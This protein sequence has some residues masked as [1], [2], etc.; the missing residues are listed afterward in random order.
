M[1][2]PLASHMAFAED[3]SIEGG[4]RYSKYSEG[5]TTNT[6]KIG[7]EWAPVRDVRLRGSFQRAVRAPNIGELFSPQ[8]VGLDGSIDPCAGTM[9]PGVSP[10]P[11]QCLAAGVPLAQYGNV[12]KNPSPQYNGLLGGNPNL[13][14]ETADTYTVGFV[15]Q[16]RFAS[17]LTLSVDY[18]DIKIKNVIAFLG[19]NTI[20]LDCIKSLSPQFCN[21]IHRDQ[22][23]SLW[24]TPEGFITDTTV[25]EGELSTKGIDLK[26]SYRVGLPALGSLLL[27]IEGT[28]TQNLI[29]TSVPGFGSY[30]CVGFY[31]ATCG[32]ANP[33]W[34]HVL[35][36]GWNTPWDGLDLNLR[37]RYIGAD[38]SEQ[39]SGN[40]FLA[41]SSFAA[42]H[43]HIPAYNYIDVTG[44]FNIYKNVRL[45]LGMN[46]IAD[47]APPIVAGA[48]C[49]TSSP[50]GANCN[51]NTFPGVYD[52]LGRYIFASFTASF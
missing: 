8:A 35:N 3:L 36:V 23:N 20:I 16:P 4:Y 7:L 38:N 26:G 11:A 9:T 21:A 5:F 47:K 51:G 33:K 10:T 32:A 19:G 50:A 13:L 24:L 48:D 22:F 40:S 17:G 14:P 42:G 44:T 18:F 45:E 12:P 25:N 41:G 52:A 29:T 28:R 39:T 27:S 6:Y 49:S 1:R 43:S 30:D 46:N 37:W 2:L 34:R 31:G 15:F